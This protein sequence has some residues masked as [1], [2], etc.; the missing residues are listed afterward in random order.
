MSSE[1]ND[2][3]DVIPICDCKIVLQSYKNKK[4]PKET[5]KS[6]KHGIEN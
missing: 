6:I 4:R 5:N 3:D 2:D 1:E